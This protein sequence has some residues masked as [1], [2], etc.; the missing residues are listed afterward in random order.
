VRHARDEDLDQLEPLLAEL[1]TVAGLREK[2][3]GNFSR[4][5]RAFLH[6]HADPSGLYADVRLGDEFERFRV[7]TPREQRT[8][9]ER[10]RPTLV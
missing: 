4:G 1:R 2:T 8:L 3:R 10:I 9:L 6:F 7:T 5:S